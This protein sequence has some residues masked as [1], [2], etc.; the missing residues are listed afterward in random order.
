MSQIVNNVVSKIKAAW[1]WICGI[2]MD[3]Y[4]F[5]ANIFNKIG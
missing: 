3:I 2:M 5:F 1:E 4:D